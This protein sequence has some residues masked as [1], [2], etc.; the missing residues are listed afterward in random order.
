MKP[1]TEAESYL[2]DAKLYLDPEN[3]QE[4][5]PSRFPI[6]YSS[7]EVHPKATP[8]ENN[9]EKL[10][11]MAN[12]EAPT[13]GKHEVK[14]PPYSWVFR[15]VVRLNN[16]EKKNQPKDHISLPFK[17]RKQLKEAKVKDLH[18][19]KAEL[20][21]PITGLHPLISSD[22]PIPEDQYRTCRGHLARKLTI[23]WQKSGYD[24]FAPSRLNKL[25]PELTREKIHR[26]TKAQNK[27]RKQGFRVDQPRLG[28]GFIPD[29]PIKIRTRK[30]AKYATV[31]YISTDKGK[32]DENQK[33]NDNRIFVFKQLRN[34]TA[35]ASVFERLGGA[36]E[37]ISNQYK[38][39]PMR[40]RVRSPWPRSCI[41]VQKE[42]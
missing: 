14:K 26:L 6:C 41:T 32:S 2:T 33:P 28:L 8:I 11:E 19:I 38:T 34:P 5:L 10:S 21:M 42:R 40:I 29:E 12:D 3:M 25:N 13:K 7:K 4:V 9:N 20:V 17:E 37:D 36:S 24:F 39:T 16:K 22:S 30:D 27:L 15:Y 35:R 18:A 31:Q 23:F 1:F